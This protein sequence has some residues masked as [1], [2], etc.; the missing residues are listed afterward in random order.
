MV[1]KHWNKLPV[2][3]VVSF[4]TLSCVTCAMEPNSTVG[5]DLQKCIPTHMTLQ[6]C[7]LCPIAMARTVKTETPL[8]QLITS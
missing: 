1:I 8:L 4:W 5:L 7:D 3:S 2:L 6:F